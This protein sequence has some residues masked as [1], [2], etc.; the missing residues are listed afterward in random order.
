VTP[1]IAESI[2]DNA[3]AVLK[4]ATDWLE[5]ANDP[6]HHAHEERAAKP[7]DKTWQQ[8]GEEQRDVIAADLESRA[9]RLYA[10]AT[11]RVA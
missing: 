8:W 11:A 6:E 9:H 4:L 10:L 7:H 3:E 5:C 2:R 1:D